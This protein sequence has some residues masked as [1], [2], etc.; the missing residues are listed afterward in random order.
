MVDSVGRRGAR[1]PQRVHGGRP[2]ERDRY[3]LDRDHPAALAGT[4]VEAGHEKDSGSRGDRASEGGGRSG[5]ETAAALGRATRTAESAAGAGVDSR[6]RLD[7]GIAE[8]SS[9]DHKESDSADG[10]RAARAAADDH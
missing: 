9:G 2:G 8:R 7:T 3:A 6:F 4:A 10:I 5:A 1:A